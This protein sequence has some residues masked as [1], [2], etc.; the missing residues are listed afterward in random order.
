MLKGLDRFFGNP[1]RKIPTGPGDSSLYLTFD[2]G[3]DP[4]G[5]EETLRVLRRHQVPASFF[6]IAEKAKASV[7]L[8]RKIQ[9]E[10]HA[11]G[12]HSLNHTYSNFFL[13]KRALR[14]WVRKAEEMLIQQLGSIPVGFRPPAGVRTPELKWVLNELK[15]PLVLWNV[16]FFDKTVQWTKKRAVD[17]LSSTVNG[18]IVLLHDHQ[19]SKNLQAFLSTLDDYILAAKSQGFKFKALKRKLGTEELC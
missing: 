17:S 13:G 8:V 7:A 9:E 16:R 5:T 11:I 15:I 1:I 12:N 3:P 18:S 6:V 19:N 10:G 14:E 4:I 2:D